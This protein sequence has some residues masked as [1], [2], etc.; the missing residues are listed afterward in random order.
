MG[1][2]AET[3]AVVGGGASG[4][5]SA[6]HLL[7][8]SPLPV[9]VV[10][11]EPRTAFGR[12]VAFGTGDPDHFLNARSTDGLLW[13]VGP[14]RRGHQWETTA[15]PDIRAQAADLARSPWRIGAMVSA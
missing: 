1:Q 8:D 2:K 5:L 13:L 14:L 3:L 7:R 12:G 15:I 6:I 9:R 4:V 10:L 11:I